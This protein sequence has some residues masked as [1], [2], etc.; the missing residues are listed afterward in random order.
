[1]T[2]QS[3][4]LFIPKIITNKCNCYRKTLAFL[5]C[6]SSFHQLGFK[7][8]YKP[9]VTTRH[10]RTRFH[11]VHVGFVGNCSVFIE[12]LHR[13]NWGMHYINILTTIKVFPN[14]SEG[15]TIQNLTKTSVI[16]R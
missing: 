4:L 14:P 3:V 16:I 13:N 2:E 15:I 7:I 11:Q 6:S 10:G 12:L 9:K 1:M 5:S 8:F